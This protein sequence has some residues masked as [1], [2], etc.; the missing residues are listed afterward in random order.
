MF[1]ENTVYE[2]MANGQP[3]LVYICAVVFPIFT[4]VV[5]ISMHFIFL[6]IHTYSASK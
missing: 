1:A 4:H 5:H 6:Y 2:Y 3:V